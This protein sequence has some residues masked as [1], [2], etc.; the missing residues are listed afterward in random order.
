MRN[1]GGRESARGKHW[2]SLS[3]DEGVSLWYELAW[4][5]RACPSGR[6]WK[7]DEV[8]FPQS[9]GNCP[10]WHLCLNS[11]LSHNYFCTFWQGKGLSGTFSLALLLKESSVVWSTVLQ[12]SLRCSGFFALLSAQCIHFGGKESMY[13]LAIPRLAVNKIFVEQIHKITQEHKLLTI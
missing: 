5:S 4:T 8:P 9:H 2:L 12:S 11:F 6:I 13:K 7:K 10:K 3:H 1:R